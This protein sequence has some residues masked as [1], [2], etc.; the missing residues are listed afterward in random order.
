MSVSRKA[1]F[2]W[3]LC[4]VALVSVMISMCTA[5]PDFLELKEEAKAL[6]AAIE[7]YK[8]QQ[9]HYPA[10]LENA[11][12]R[13]PSTSFGKWRYIPLADKTH[14][15]QLGDYLFDGFVLSYTSHRGWSL[16]Q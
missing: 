3:I 5:S 6:I 15:I 11:G 1:K 7:E 13:S 2:T 10:S 12:L 14:E 4:V 16:D 9:G 8:T